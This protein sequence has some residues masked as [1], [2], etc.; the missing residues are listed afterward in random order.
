MDIKIE[1]DLR[2]WMPNTS[3]MTD[4]KIH[5]LTPVQAF[6]HEALVEGMFGSDPFWNGPHTKTKIF[7]LF[8]YQSRRNEHT[9]K[10]VFA[11]ELKKLVEV[12]E[13]R[14]IRDRSW[15]FT[16]AGGMQVRL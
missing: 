14:P 7:E 2:S 3:A 12:K 8:R 16:P 11:K 1:K 4:S 5:S 9:T 15:T 6:W 13:T 10:E